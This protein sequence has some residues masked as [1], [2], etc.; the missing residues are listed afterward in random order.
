MSLF[1][2]IFAT[3][4]RMYRDSEM[5]IWFTSGKGLAALLRPLFRFAWPVLLVIMA[6]ALLVLPW[7]NQRIEHL[8]QQYEKRGDIERVEPGQFQESAGGKRVFFIEKD[9][10]G[11]QAGSNVFIA[12]TENGKETITSARSGRVQH[13]EQGRFLMLNN[14]QRLENA[15]DKT[16]LKISEFEEYGIKVDAEVPGN[17]DFVQ[18]N[19]RPTLE[20]LQNQTLPNLAEL[21]WRIGLILA[22]MNF[23]IIGVAVSSAN[24]RVRRGA[25]LVFALFAFILYNNLLNLGQNWIALGKFTFGGFLLAL[26]G[27]AL[28]LGLLWLAKGHNNWSWLTLSSLWRPTRLKSTT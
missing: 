25:N 13:T 28:L 21:S 3:L 26:H 2:S 4:S 11:K 16:E 15:L 12:T 10:S 7:S 22:A 19:T 5:V 23:V 14:G 17:A 1:I 9:A 20:L 24:P 8:K 18:T 27:G 6:L